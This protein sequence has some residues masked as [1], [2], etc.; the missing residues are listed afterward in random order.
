MGYN[1]IFPFVEN[2]DIFV[3]GIL[4]EKET[5]EHRL[6]E[7]ITIITIKGHK[8]TGLYGP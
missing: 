1:N 7:G 8:L 5:P 2:S 3:I 4:Y 6:S